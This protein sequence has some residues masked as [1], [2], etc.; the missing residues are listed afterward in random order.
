MFSLTFAI[1]FVVFLASLTLAGKLPA[2]ALCLYLSASIVSFAVYWFD[3]SAA[4][5]G[6][7]RTRESTLHLLSLIG[8]WPGALVAQRVLRHKSKKQSFQVVF[9]ATLLLNCAVL[10][11][12][13]MPRGS[14][15]ALHPQADRLAS[16]VRTVKADQQPE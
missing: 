11:W 8:G 4:Q 10:L 1:L 16:A 9:W 13:L 6:R 3:K 15:S 5:A 2:A 14:G 12:S 7:W